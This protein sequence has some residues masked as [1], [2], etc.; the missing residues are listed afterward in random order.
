MQVLALVQFPNFLFWVYEHRVDSLGEQLEAALKIR[1]Q[2]GKPF[3]PFQ[4]KD[5]LTKR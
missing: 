3:S 5:Y 4:K 2:K 1:E